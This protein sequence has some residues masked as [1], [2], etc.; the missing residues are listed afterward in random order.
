MSQNK[1]KTRTRAKNQEI[2]Q[3]S[4]REQREEG[5]VKEKSETRHRKTAK[6]TR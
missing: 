6:G 4:K 2:D 5:S 1:Y 3:E